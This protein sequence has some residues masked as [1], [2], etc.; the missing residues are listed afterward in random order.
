MVGGV[1]PLY[2]SFVT[3][4]EWSSAAGALAADWTI[5]GRYRLH[6]VGGDYVGRDS[7]D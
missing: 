5:V 2:T 4:V 6:T 7:S 3:F 1:L